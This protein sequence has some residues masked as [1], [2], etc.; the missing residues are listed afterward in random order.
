ME[1]KSADK[2]LIL[3]SLCVVFAVTAT[4]YLFPE[5]S[6]VTANLIFSKIT[7]FL[8]SPILL[9]TL[10]GTVLLVYLA[11]SK[12]GNIKLG[13][14]EP[15]FSTFRWVSMMISCGLGAGTIYWAYLEWAYY[16][17]TP[18]LGIEAYS[19]QAYEMAVAYPFF[20]W[21]VSA[22]ALYAL[23]GIPM[24]YHCYIRKNSGLSLSGITCSVLGLGEKSIWRRIID[25]IF[26]F[27]CFGGISVMLCMSAPLIN[28]V[29]C[30]LLGLEATFASTVTLLVIVAFIY[31]FSSVI[32]IQKGMARISDWNIKLMMIFIL[33]IVIIGPTEFITSNVISSLGLMAQN[34]VTMS[35]FTDP[36]NGST[37]TQDWTVFY[38]L[39]WISYAPFTGVF[40]AKISKGRTIRAVVVN[41]LVSGS[42]GCFALFGVMGSLG[43]ERQL[44]GAVDAVSMLA[45]GND[46]LAIVEILGTLPFSVVVM[47][48]F[49]ISSILFLATTLDSAAFT[50]A[51]T[52]MPQLKNGQ[53]PGPM[54]K[55]FWCILLSL[56]PLTL[57][58]INADLN[59]IKTAVIITSTPVFF[60]MI[61]IVYGWMKWMKEDYKDK[62]T[63]Q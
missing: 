20:H 53:D 45:Q 10:L 35:L 33:I 15:E 14:G 26:V 9:L 37:F 43:L 3:I 11:I 63:S 47:T 5:Q 59:T 41:T 49:C 16:I 1:K 48:I 40:I 39:F 23:L 62:P 31:S 18:G 30:H 27:I 29:L 12:Y 46:T 51:V 19:T 17:G 22:W 58:L 2:V 36:I 13:E 60:I 50:L 8:T 54:Q 24:A 21:G 56:V 28:E 32:G 61:L 7:T 52:S 34:F 25:V 38:W 55:L 44:S 42:V 4:L 57:I 6:Q